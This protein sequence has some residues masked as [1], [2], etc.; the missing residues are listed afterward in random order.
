[1]GDEIALLFGLS[2]PFVVRQQGST[3]FKLVGECFVHGIM[4]GEAM[5][6]FT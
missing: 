5:E 2:A 1:V 4:D 3:D 6:G